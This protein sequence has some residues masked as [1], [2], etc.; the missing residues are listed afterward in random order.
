MLLKEKKEKNQNKTKP[1]MGCQFYPGSQRWK[2][3]LVKIKVVSFAI[4]LCNLWLYVSSSKQSKM[5]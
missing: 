2:G 5:H 4:S 1:E 3:W